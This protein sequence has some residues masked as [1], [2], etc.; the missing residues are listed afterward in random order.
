MEYTMNFFKTEAPPVRKPI[1]VVIKLTSGNLEMFCCEVN[2]A[3][4]GELCFLDTGD[5]IGWGVEDITM[6]AP[7][8]GLIAAVKEGE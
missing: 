3:Y 6:W 2:D 8:A 5:S 1:L 4:I 7:L